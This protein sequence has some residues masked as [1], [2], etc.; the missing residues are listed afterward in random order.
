MSSGWVRRQLVGFFWSF[1]STDISCERTYFDADDIEVSSSDDSV[2]TVYT[3]TLLKQIEGPSFSMASV[4]PN[5]DLTSVVIIEA[6]YQDST[7]PLSG[8]YYIKCP[9]EAG[10]DFI[11]TDMGIGNWAAGIDFNVH[12]QIPH[13]QFKT[14]IRSTGK[15]SYSVNGLEIMML[16]DGYHGDVPLCTIHSSETD[17][18]T[19]NDVIEYNS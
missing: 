8:S 4:I 10:N 5:A 13:L 12:L 1:Y 16:F 7:P 14:Y 18:I 6:P 19:G 11:T 3:C 2:K 17:P 9:N 15:Y